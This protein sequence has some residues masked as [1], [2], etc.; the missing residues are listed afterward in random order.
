M[1]RQGISINQQWTGL[2]TVPDPDRPEFR[3]LPIN[4]RQLILSILAVGL[5]SCSAAKPPATPSVESTPIVAPTPS[6][7]PSVSPSPKASTRPSKESSNLDAPIENRAEPEGSSNSSGAVE[8]A[9]V[10]KNK[11][12]VAPAEKP[13]RTEK[14]AP[15]IEPEA[16]VPQP[17]EIAPAPAAAPKAPK[18]P[19]APA[20]SDDPEPPAL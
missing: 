18:A 3:K 9:P 8:E 20:Q 16:P 5:V 7:T 15:A 13:Q 6:P 12:I 4:F 19:T 2:L 17:R 10:T 14:P 1:K 11:T